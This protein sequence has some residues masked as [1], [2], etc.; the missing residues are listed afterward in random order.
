MYSLFKMTQPGD[1]KKCPTAKA[2]CFGGSN[3][4]PKPGYWRKNNI[5]SNFIKCLYENACL[6][7]L[8]P[9]NNPIGKC[10]TGY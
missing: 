1:C 3:I 8:P 2:I 5:T 9:D 10:D 6:G 7:M 4:G